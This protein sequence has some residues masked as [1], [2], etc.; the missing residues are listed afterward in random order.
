VPASVGVP[1]S[2]P[3]LLSVRP[4]GRLAA[5]AEMLSAP[6]PPDAVIVW[7]YKTPTVP[8]ARPEVV[9]LTA[10]LMVTV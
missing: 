8:L 5:G 1:E 7:L 9:M 6:V 3:L 4:V 2:T 10:G